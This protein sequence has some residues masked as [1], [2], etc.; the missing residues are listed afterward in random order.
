LVFWDPA[1]GEPGA[2]S[3]GE[4]GPR[5]TITKDITQPSSAIQTATAS[6]R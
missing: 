3:D 6:K 5:R 1:A 2:A 4:P